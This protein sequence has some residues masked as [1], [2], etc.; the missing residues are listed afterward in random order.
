VIGWLLISQI[1]VSLVP[2]VRWSS[3]RKSLAKVVKGL[4]PTALE[5]PAALIALRRVAD[6]QSFWSTNCASR[7]L[8]LTAPRPCMVPLAE[9]RECR[10]L[11]APQPPILLAKTRLSARSDGEDHD[12][13][14]TGSAGRRAAPRRRSIQA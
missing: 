1:K 14:R 13:C 4:R 6:E 2:P 7:L 12:P 10:G 8:L 9:P 3:V 11:D 5:I